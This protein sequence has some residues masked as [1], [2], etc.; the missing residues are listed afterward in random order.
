MRGGSQAFYVPSGHLV[1][2]AA[3]TLRA[4]RFDLDRHEVMGTAIPVVSPLVIL[5]TGAADFD[6]ARDGTLAYVVGGTAGDGA[7]HAGM[8]RPPEA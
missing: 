5:P 8:G 1:Y 4:V 3:G 6:I 2:V 7:A